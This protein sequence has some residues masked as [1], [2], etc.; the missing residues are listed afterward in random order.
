MHFTNYLFQCCLISIPNDWIKFGKKIFS[1]KIYII[2]LLSCYF[3]TLRLS[4]AT[5]TLFLKEKQRYAQ[6]FRYFFIKL[7]LG[8]LSRKLGRHGEFGTK[9]HLE[10][11]KKNGGRMFIS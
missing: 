8:T 9:S 7:F 5:A 1:F 10:P 2:N 6:N 4:L 3:L 11:K